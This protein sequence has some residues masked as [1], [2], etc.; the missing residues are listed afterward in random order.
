MI[1][2]ILPD[3]HLTLSDFS[4]DLPQEQIAQTPMTPR[5]ASR[6]LVMDRKTGAL[7][8]RIF[9]DIAEYIRPQDVLVINDTKV[10]PARIVGR[11]AYKMKNGT[12]EKTDSSG[13]RKRRYGRHWRAPAN[14][15]GQAIFWNSAMGSCKPMLRMS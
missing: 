15:P 12:L 5:D 9:R 7:E 11:R 10:I 13:K 6:L 2:N 14:G 1:Q 4:Y 8:H 3:T